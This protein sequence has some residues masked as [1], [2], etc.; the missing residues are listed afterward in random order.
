MAVFYKALTI[1]NII[2]SWFGK[3]KSPLDAIIAPEISNDLFYEYLFKI[4][5]NKEF[6]TYIEIGSSAGQGSTQAFFNGINCRDDKELVSLYCLEISTA[7][8]E[9]L[10]DTYKKY[11]FIKPFNLSSIES[12]LFPSK[13]KVAEFYNSNINHKLKAYPLELVQ[14]WRDNDLAYLNVH[15]K[16]NANGIEI[17]KKT[18]KIKNFD[19]ALID[20]S[21]F[22][23]NVELDFVM[24]AKMI[25][26]DDT[27]TFKCYEAKERLSKD[28]RYK[29][30]IHDPSVRNGFAIFELK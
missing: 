4:A 3:I 14:S 17:I 22:T 25:A 8:F 5:Q 11:S 6:K 20:G 30:V 16:N 15:K 23:G 12:S 21:E 19:F 9:I 7:R 27:E 28:D 26:L 18:F 2:K 29:L 10:K 1:M 13:E 24:G